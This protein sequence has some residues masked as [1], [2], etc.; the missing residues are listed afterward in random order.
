MLHHSS[1][2]GGL[3]RLLEEGLRSLLPRGGDEKDA[4]FASTGPIP[5]LESER[6]LVSCCVEPLWG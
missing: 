4:D 1:A 5:G 6:V 2:K 3:R